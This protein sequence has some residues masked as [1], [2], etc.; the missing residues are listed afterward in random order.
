MTAHLIV[1]VLIGCTVA[2]AYGVAV[3]PRKL[4]DAIEATRPNRAREAQ[5]QAE[6]LAELFRNEIAATKRGDLLAAAGFAERAE[7]IRG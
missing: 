1:L 3:F 4:R 5:T 2:I 6:A 7:V